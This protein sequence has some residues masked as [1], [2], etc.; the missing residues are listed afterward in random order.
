MRSAMSGLLPE[1][2]RLRKD[3]KGFITPEERWVR[4]DNPAWFRKRIEE[5]VSVTGKIIK[6]EALNFY[7]KVVNGEKKFD[8]TY[9]RIIL[10]SLWMEKFNIRNPD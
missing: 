4:Q 8:Y 5:A 1:E 3:K 7:D 9:W 6:P 2:I 10:F